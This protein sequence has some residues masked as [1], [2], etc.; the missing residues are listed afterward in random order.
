MRT[1]AMPKVAWSLTSLREK[2]DQDRRQSGRY[3]TFQLAEVAV[4]R[5]MFADIL[6]V[7]AQLRGATRTGVTGRWSQMRQT[8]TAEVRLDERNATG[9]SL[10]SRA[11]R[12]FGCQRGWPRSNFVARRPDET[13]DHAQR[14]GNPGNV[15]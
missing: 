7:T 3:A 9:C 12:R 1:L 4:S 5:Q 8:T 6:M 11:T 10:A 15:G 13:E 14:T 2:A